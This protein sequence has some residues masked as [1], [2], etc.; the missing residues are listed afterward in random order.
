MEI[1]IQQTTQVSAL[2][3]SLKKLQDKEFDVLR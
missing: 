1:V 3:I 2:K